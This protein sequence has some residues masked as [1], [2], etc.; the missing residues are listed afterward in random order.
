MPD[1]HGPA[2][3]TAYLSARDVRTLRWQIYL[4]LAVFGWGIFA[5]LAQS[6]DRVMSP[7]SSLWRL[8]PGQQN[9]YQGLTAHGVL[10]VL[11]FTFAFINGFQVLVTSHA[12]KRSPNRWLLDGAFWLMLVGAGMAALEIVGNRASVLFT[13]YPPLQAT[14]VYYLG[15]VL[16]VVSTWLMVLNT[17]LMYRAWRHDNPGER[18][19]LQAFAVLCNAILWFVASVGVAIETL[20]SLAQTGW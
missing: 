7:S 6:L 19:P 10:M 11:V 18:I 14:P 16:V 5:G 15:L 20:G 2:A 9:Y 4:S 1:P 12:L 3:V 17:V 13:M 8:F